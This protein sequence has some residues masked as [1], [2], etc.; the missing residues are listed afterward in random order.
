MI[1]GL[2]LSIFEETGTR[3]GQTLQGLRVVQDQVSFCHLWLGPLVLLDGATIDG[4]NHEALSFLKSH[5]LPTVP[6]CVICVHRVSPACQGS[7]M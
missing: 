1:M 2:L 5:S 6:D 3:E 4:E 7:Y